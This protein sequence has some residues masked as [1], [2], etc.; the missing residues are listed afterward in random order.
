MDRLLGLHDYFYRNLHTEEGGGV[1]LRLEFTKKG[2][3][4]VSV[5]L[6]AMLLLSMLIPLLASAA[7][8]FNIQFDSLTGKVYGY[9]YSDKPSVSVSVYDNVYGQ[10][11]IVTNTAYT[12]V[13]NGVYYYRLDTPSNSELTGHSPV[14]A[15][16]Y[17]GTTPYVSVNR[18]VYSSVYVLG[19][20][21]TPSAPTGF[22]AALSGGNLST[23]WPMINDPMIK[24]I[25]L[26]LNGDKYHSGNSRN[27]EPNGY[28][29]YW[30]GSSLPYYF[31][32]TYNLQ[33]SVTDVAG[34]ES[35]LSPAIT[36]TA[37]TQSAGYH[38]SGT[39][40]MN[41]NAQVGTTFVVKDLTGNVVHSITYNGSVVSGT[42]SV[43]RYEI[44]NNYYGTPYTDRLF[45]FFD[46]PD[47]AYSITVTNAINTKTVTTNMTAPLPI[48]L[49]YSANVSYGSYANIYVNTTYLKTSFASEPV[50]LFNGYGQG[51]YMQ[52]NEGIVNFTPD[53]SHAN[54][55]NVRFPYDKW[56]FGGVLSSNSSTTLYADK[57]APSDFQ[58]RKSSDN[59]LVGIVSAS[60]DAY[61]KGLLKLSLSSELQ[62][63]QQY[64]LSMSQA[65]GG[66][67]ILLPLWSGTKFSAYVSTRVG[68]TQGPFDDIDYSLADQTI[69]VVAA[70][71]TQTSAT[72][73][74]TT[75]TTTQSTNQPPSTTSDSVKLD[76]KSITVTKET[77][78]DG[79]PVT[80][81]TVDADMMGK[82]L[83]LLKDKDNG[84]RV[85]T[86]E[87]SGTEAAAKV[88]IPASALTEA[89]G[90]KLDAVISIKT[91]VATY[92]VPID[93]FKDLA[94]ALKSDLKDVKVTVSI[95]K[96][97]ETINQAIQKTNPDVKPLLA[98]PIE[99]T[100]TAE[101]SNG[102]KM[103][104]N[105]FGGTYVERKILVPSTVDS[106]RTTAVVIDL[107]TGQMKFIPA[108]ITN[109][110]G[111]AEVTIK[112]SHNSVYTLVEQKK[113]F[114]D[115]NG[116]WAKDDIEL[117]ASK[118]IVQGMTDTN[119][120]PELKVTRAQFASM[121]VTALG[122]NE[123]AAAAKFGDV[124]TNSWF[125][126]AV[127][128]AAKADIVDGMDNGDFAPNAS[129]TREQ[130]AVMIS[131]AIKAAGKYADVT[132]TQDQTLARFTDSG[133]I[134]GWAKSAVT[135]AVDAK[136]VTGL[137]DQT[138]VPSD[139]ATRAQA[140]VMLK[141]FLQYVQFIN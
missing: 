103:D 81:L 76:P 46:L 109:T 89:L 47:T 73:P 53:G 71:S 21:T 57:L 25:N 42:T 56:P 74:T 48:S 64:V 67:E 90:S 26:Y 20:A 121:L 3:R 22:T 106:S 110:D 10:K 140:A 129:I 98:N 124:N 113:S 85:V 61:I 105:D 93:I 62:A 114:D 136:I 8:L 72:T 86:I 2:I 128:A 123:D 99:F 52:P 28:F 54:Y 137:T 115:L 84:A 23:T 15:T 120:A 18:S 78:T 59:S 102:S 29:S 60:A 34:H 117:L 80:R 139:Y 118:L 100:I 83:G 9:V 138:F 38:Y 7:S 50:Y 14:T 112:S 122:L 19:N 1:V 40:A 11:N 45:Y 96:A 82:A 91:D 133:Q 130:M 12:S 75:T 35:P 43:G 87:A 13:T 108:I 6:A 27:L 31:G 126:G 135:Q 127:G 107:K 5:T 101:S 68:E 79:K 30:T 17:E 32:G 134:H 51:H 104:I 95:T 24:T 44:T 141:R 119:F 37:P 41:G 94:S 66:N 55:L 69:S 88:D 39:V 70:P 33:M 77:G 111:K 36:L 65:S 16:V 63:G 132:A 4:R 116:H 49:Y 97:S 92:N 125:A 58:L 131:R